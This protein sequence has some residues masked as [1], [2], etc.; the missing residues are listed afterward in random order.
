MLMLTE[1]L[2]HSWVLAASLML[3]NYAEVDVSVLNLQNTSCLI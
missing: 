3:N 2:L 1:T